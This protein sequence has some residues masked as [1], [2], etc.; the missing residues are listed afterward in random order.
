MMLLLVTVAIA[1]TE[2]PCVDRPTPDVLTAL[3]APGG[4]LDGP[5]VIW[6]H[7]AATPDGAAFVAECSAK[8]DSPVQTRESEWLVVGDAIEWLGGRTDSG[9]D[10]R[11]DGPV[12]VRPSTRVVADVPVYEVCGVH[13]TDWNEETHERDDQSCLLVLSPASTR[14]VDPVGGARSVLLV[15]HGTIQHTNQWSFDV[16][17]T[18]TPNDGGWL[19]TVRYASS[20]KSGGTTHTRILYDAR[21]RTFRT[22]RTERCSPVET[23]LASISPICPAAP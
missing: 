19:E 14:D 8:E 3:R 22:A 16:S 21:S 9:F 23:A 10:Y 18:L 4:Q 7:L 12:T 13:V 5:A 6:K 20:Q 1:D 2:D 17:D 11:M 15:R